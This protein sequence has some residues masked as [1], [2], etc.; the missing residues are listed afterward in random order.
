[1]KINISLFLLLI[2]AFSTW[3]TE[4]V[5]G[6]ESTKPTFVNQTC[7]AGMRKAYQSVYGREIIHIEIGSN[8]EEGETVEDVRER[9]IARNPEEK[10][11]LKNLFI[12]PYNFILDG[13]FHSTLAAE[14]RVSQSEN[15]KKWLILDFKREGLPLLLEPW[16]CLDSATIRFGDVAYGCS[17]IEKRV[18]GKVIDGIEV[19]QTNDGKEQHGYFMS[20]DGKILMFWFLPKDFRSAILP[21]V[22]IATNDG[23][24]IKNLRN[25]ISLEK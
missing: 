13:R 15:G 4:L 8:I 18:L 25:C 10:H 14:P 9:I 17:W 23:I 7:I 12:S 20:A 6:S 1:M 22:Y 16:R 11:E 2:F 5:S 24:D 3:G 21:E 19:H